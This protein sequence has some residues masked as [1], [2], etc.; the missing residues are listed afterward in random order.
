[1][2]MNIFTAALTAVMP[3]MKKTIAARNAK[4]S[5]NAIISTPKPTSIRPMMLRPA[6]RLLEACENKFELNLKAIIIPSFFTIRILT[7]IVLYGK[8]VK[9]TNCEVRIEDWWGLIF[10]E[11]DC[12]G[13]F[14]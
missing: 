12:V 14:F 2:L 4:S 1:M 9:K 7:V 3:A 5:G 13:E 8:W 11:G 10:V 6:A